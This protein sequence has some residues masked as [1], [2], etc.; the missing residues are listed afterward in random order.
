MFRIYAGKDN[1][2]AP[3]SKDNI[4]YKPKKYFTISLKGVEE[5]D[6]T[7]IYGFPGRTQEYLHSAGVRYIGEISDPHKIRLRTIRLGIQK[8]YMQQSQ[9]IRIRYSSK[10]ASVANAWKKWQG[11]AKGLRK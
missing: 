7:F 4:P 5:G 11:E 2:P 6:F 3:Y 8:K 9:D 10:N 1:M